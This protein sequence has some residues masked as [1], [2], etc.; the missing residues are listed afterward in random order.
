MLV[1]ATTGKLPSVKADAVEFRLDLF[2]DLSKVS[3]LRKTCSLPVIFTLRKASQGGKFLGNERERQDKILELLALKPDYVDLEYDCDLDFVREVR[4]SASLI[5]SYH[6]FEKTPEDLSA[7]LTEM[8]RL[9]ASI[10]KIATQAPSSL[11]ALRMLCFVREKRLEDEPIAG[12]CMGEHGGVTRILAPVVDSL[13]TYAAHDV[14]TAPGQLSAKVL[15]DTYH[16]SHLN[17]KTAIYSLIGNPVDQS[18]G[19]HF[20]NALFKQL[21]EDAVYVKIALKPE[22]IPAFFP[23]MKQLLFK[24]FSVTMP[25][26]E[27]V[28]AYLDAIDPSARSMG[29]IN[30]LAYL[31]GE[32]KGFNTD[33]GGALDAIETQGNVAGKKVVILG[34]GG[35]ARALAYESLQ[36]GATVRIV[37][38]TKEKG[39]RLAHQ[40]GCQA[41]ALEEWTLPDYD[42]LMNTTPASPNVPI[43]EE[44]ILS[45]RLIFDAVFN[46]RGTALLNL[47]Q[48][49][50]CTVVDGHEM[51]VRQAIKQLEIWLN[52]PV[53]PKLAPSL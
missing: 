53:D 19:H 30:T 17:R 26:K 16:Y 37:N 12:M 36:R 52:Q 42:I 27:K 47:A 45:G 46:L 38:R 44:K 8:K 34:A 14:E 10:Y 32:W 48:N 41:T 13:I 9:P 33:A 31:D 20:H 39:D 4:A 21:K 1:V 35:A 6:D 22:E 11:D 51:Y 2:Q 7:I 24:G 25:L 43:P 5:C 15:E 23:L 29:A 28:G 49:K 3:K 50:G 18:I 40:L